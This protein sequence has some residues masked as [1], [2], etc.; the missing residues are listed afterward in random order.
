MM[1]NPAVQRQDAFQAGLDAPYFWKKGSFQGVEP[2]GWRGAGNGWNGEGCG[3][4]SVTRGDGTGFLRSLMACSIKSD[5]GPFDDPAAIRKFSQDP[6]AI[7]DVAN[8]GLTCLQIASYPP[9]KTISA[10]GFGFW[11]VDLPTT[12][13]AQIDL[14]L[15]IMA[16]NLK[17][18]KENGGLYAL[19]EFCDETGQNVTRQYLVGG[20]DGRKPVGAEWMTGNYK[21][22]QLAGMV[23]A[24]RGA[25]WFKLG[26]GLRNCSGWV[27]LSDIDIHTRPGVPEAEVKRVLPIDASKFAWTVC[28]LSGLLN[29]P[30]ADEVDNDGQGGWT[31]QGPNMDLRN[32]Q[33]G[34]YTWNDVA[35][36]VAK[37][38]A[39]FIMKNSY[40]PSQNLPAGGKV[41][42]KGHADV[43]AFLHSGGWISAGAR[44][45]TYI[46]HY[47]DGTKVEI[48]VIGGENI[49]DWT[50]PAARAD[51][52]K[53][54]PALG[55]ILPATSVASPQFVHVTVWMTLW[56][57]PYPDKPI[58]ALEV[59]GANAGIP[60]LIAV[61]RGQKN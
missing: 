53:Y 31:D 45:A 14:S 41:K 5:K 35:F 30:L 36:R 54:D 2:Y 29:R 43:L 6:V 46:I 59:K 8:D 11:S 19:A 23:T 16:K 1:G 18:A 42:F 57:N 51:E 56:K 12:D 60:G 33:A 40:R 52:I 28:D 48:P 24:P 37:G 13:A 17:A 50:A 26:F 44:Q 20:K 38:N 22:K 3:F 25:R 61:S 55:L 15:W 21:Y 32:L 4:S 47:A 27:A 34:D 7:K 58:V 10:E 49:L 39:C 9:D